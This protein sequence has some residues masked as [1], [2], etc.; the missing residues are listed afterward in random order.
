VDDT[1]GRHGWATRL[2]DTA[3]GWGMMSDGAGSL[4]PDR[5]V[6]GERGR[7]VAPQRPAHRRG[8]TARSAGD[9]G[10]GRNAVA[11]RRRWWHRRR[12]LADRPP[13]DSRSRRCGSR[14]APPAPHGSRRAVPVARRSGT[15]LG[16][17]RGR[18]GRCR[19]HT[20]TRARAPFRELGNDSPG[21]DHGG[22]AESGFVP[23]LV[24]PGHDGPAAVGASRRRHHDDHRPSGATG[25]RPWCR[26]A[27]RAAWRRTRRSGGRLG[28]RPD[29]GASGIC[30]FSCR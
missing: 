30:S 22:G 20:W 17:G 10:R 3:S 18:R 23:Q 25:R 28:R 24:D 12:R 27:W 2:G 26:R 5:C 13:R 6:Q 29:S 21:R 15:G 14:D 11:P 7:C 9:G 1:A 8:R 4:G 19:P 16:G